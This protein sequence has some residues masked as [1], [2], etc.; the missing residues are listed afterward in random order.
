MFATNLVK[1]IVP[2]PAVR[3]ESSALSSLPAEPRYPKRKRA[4]VRYNC[5]DNE[6]VESDSELQ[7]IPVKVLSF[8]VSYAYAIHQ[9][10]AR[11]TRPPPKH[12][13]FPFMSLPAEL[14]NKIYEDCLPSPTRLP[15]NYE[16]NKEAIWLCFKQ[17]RYRRTVDYVP[18]LDQGEIASMQYGDYS[19]SRR[20]ST[21]RG[22]IVHHANNDNDNS[23]LDVEE[24]EA[25]PRR[26]G[27]NILS[28]SKQIYE[29]AAPMMYAQTLVFTDVNAVVAFAATL[30]PR[31]AKLLRS[32]EIRSWQQTRSRKSQGYNAMAMLAAKGVTNLTSLFINCSMGYF[33]SYSWRNNRRETAVPKR[34]ARKVYRDCHLWLEIMGSTHGDLYKGIE[35]LKLSGA[36]FDS[37]TSWNEVEEE[38]KTVYKKE[39]Q[40]LLREGAW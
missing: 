9:Q 24:P 17:K 15:E 11:N 30:S 16:G 37:E 22:R 31:T 38:D 14:R 26:L 40:R 5:E 29:E 19:A 32:I 6:D 28:V 12:K 8:T 39:L 4:D 23:D 36:M 13:I 7:Y 10:R 27:P 2:V 18:S 1:R 33:R 34:I 25:G 35:V 3:P 21:Q 20:A